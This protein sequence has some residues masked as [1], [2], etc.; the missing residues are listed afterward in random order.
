MPRT[1]LRVAPGLL[2]IS[3]LL[4]TGSFGA[5]TRS[6][7]GNS[8]PVAGD[9]NYLVH[10]PLTL[11]A[12]WVLSNDS[13]PDGDPISVT[14]ASQSTAHG[15][16]DMRADGGFTY[17]PAK[18]YV[19]EDAFVYQVCDNKGACDSATITFTVQNGAPAAA[20]DN[21][22]F[23]G[24][25]VVVAA[26]GLLGNDSDPEGDRLAVNTGWPVTLA[27]GSLDLD[28]SG[29]F[30]YTLNSPSYVGP[31]SYT[32][33]VCDDLAACSQT[34]VTINA[35]NSPPTVGA[36]GGFV[37]R[38]SFNLSPPGVLANDSDPEGD[39]ISARTLNGA[40][41]FQ[42]Q[43]LGTMTLSSL[44]SFTYSPPNSSFRGE[45]SASYKVCDN[46]GL[47]SAA[48]VSFTVVDNDD[49]ENQG[50][51][52]ASVGEPVN[53][54]N[55]NVWLQQSDYELLGAGGGLSLL[56]THNSINTRIGLFGKGWTATYEEWVKPYD[57]TSLRLYLSDGRGVNFR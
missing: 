16:I 57:A 2:V 53:V 30:K 24:G 11:P 40:P 4:F 23:H 10:R 48:T 18:G 52:C 31:D 9:D 19:G 54:T 47:C 6:Q 38:G 35:V 1:H 37:V 50:P 44:G 32:Y 42:T 43:R 29:S 28:S 34:T 46:F 15:Y 12:P 45:D 56:R 33:T 22:S 5:V 13:D 49:A 36:D 7:E 41:T 17:T 51:N 39:K 55:G 21:Y 26:P 8:A 27:H 14:P 25:Y 3:A 20:A